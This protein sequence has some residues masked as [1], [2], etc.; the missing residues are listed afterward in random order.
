[1]QVQVSTGLRPNIINIQSIDKQTALDHHVFKRKF[2]EQSWNTKQGGAW[3][4]LA[5]KEKNGLR[6]MDRRKITTPPMS[7]QETGSNFALFKETML[8]F[9]ISKVIRNWGETIINISIDGVKKTED[10]PKLEEK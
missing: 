8:S 3:K 6:I 2:T 4:L 10:E 1:M 5:D 7:K 9:S